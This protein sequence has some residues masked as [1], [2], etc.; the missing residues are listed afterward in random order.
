MLVREGGLQTHER[1]ADNAETSFLRRV[2]SIS[3]ATKIRNQRADSGA[4]SW[5][6]RGLGQ[7]VIAPLW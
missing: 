4:I 5:P 7:S 2:L 1:A 6:N 3:T